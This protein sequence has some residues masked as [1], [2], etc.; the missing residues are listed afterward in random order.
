MKYSRSFSMLA[1]A[2]LSACAA[3]PAVVSET[4]SGIIRCGGNHFTRLGG[5]E[6]HFVNYIL[7]NRGHKESITVDRLVFYDAMGALIHDSATS[8]FPGFSN[9]VLGPEK[10]VLGPNQ[11]GQLDVTSFLPYLTETQRP[12][13]A[14]IHWSAPR[15]AIPLSVDLIRLTYQW[16]PATRMRGA[17]KTRDSQDC[18]E[19]GF[20][21]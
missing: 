5:T 3:A 18:D 21:N 9:A 10:R 15:A 7:R 16:D 11:T 4:Q 19:L 14:E 20:K 13:Q 1:V 2:L 12:M 6:L 17:E 8:G